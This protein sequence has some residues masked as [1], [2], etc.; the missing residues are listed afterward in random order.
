MVSDA[1]QFP[2]RRS[3]QY[4]SLLELL[5][6]LNYQS[7]ELSPYLHEIAC[8][9]SQLLGSDWSIVTLCRDGVGQIVASNLNLDEGNRGFAT[10]TTLAGHVTRTGRSLVIED[11]QLGPEDIQPPIGYSS[12]LGVPLHAGG[13]CI[14]TVCSLFHQPHHFT[15]EAIRLAEIFAERAATAINNFQLYQQQ[16]QL[17]QALEAEIVERKQIEQKLARLA[18]IGELAVM[19]VHEIRN[20][21]T[22]VLMGLTAFQGM[23]LSSRAQERLKLA[24]DEA[25][26]LKRLLNEIL[27]YAKRQT[28]QTSELELNY[29]ITE[30]LESIRNIPAATQRN[31][32]FISSLPSA[33]VWGDQDKLKQVFI[34]LIRNACE[35]ISDG[36]KVIWRIERGKAANQVCLSVHNTGEPIPS[37]ILS[38]LGTPFFTTKSSGNGLGLAIVKQ[39]VAAHQGEL[40]IESTV[41]T[42]TIVSVYLPL[43]KFDCID[44]T[45]SDIASNITL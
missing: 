37:E 18:E 40:V 4:E 12:Y 21:L 19:I 10:H 38:Q 24:L 5:A 39:I 43:L 7:G 34:N 32:E 42:G 15:T 29:L 9:V 36:E 28:L 13:T 35:A 14:G 26:R 45:V 25:E 6:T 31:I 22:T 20:P 23:D 8:G 33:W 2:Q 41:E 16:Q 27:M 11:V 3:Q 1:L 17:I 44:N 30:M